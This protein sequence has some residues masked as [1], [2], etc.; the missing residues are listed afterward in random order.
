MPAYEPLE[1]P[2]TTSA[3]SALRT[4][5]DTHSLRKLK[6]HLL[7]A[8]GA[9]TEMA[10][11][12]N[13]RLMLKQ[14]TQQKRHA[15]LEREG[16]ILAERDKDEQDVQCEELKEEV[17]NLTAEMEGSTRKLI[18]VE[19]RTVSIEDALR[20][21]A[22]NA[23]AH[24]GALPWPSMTRAQVSQGGHRR[25]RRGLVVNNDDDEDDDSD[26]EAEIQDGEDQGQAT[27][28]QDAGLVRS[29]QKDM[30]TRQQWHDAR[31]KRQ[32]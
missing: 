24:G 23:V 1:Q 12:I 18:D 14:N 17:E 10:G 8:N 4:L 9:V 13:D 7:S 32:K 5:H 16:I 25:R 22:S 28:T 30:Q 6:A 15:R 11:E 20:E 2:L 27:S 29:F 26:Q 3:Q 21:L 31:P 19:A